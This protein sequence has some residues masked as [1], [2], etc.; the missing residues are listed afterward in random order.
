MGG[1]SDYQM[2]EVD[3]ILDFRRSAVKEDLLY[4][5]ELFKGER[6]LQNNVT[7]KQFNFTTIALRCLD[8]VDRKHLHTFIAF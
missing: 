8:Q 6:S 7:P 3:P 1:S 2:K 5:K 4:W